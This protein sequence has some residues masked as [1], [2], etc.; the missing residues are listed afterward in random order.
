MK[1]LPVMLLGPLFLPFA[2][3]GLS[4]TSNGLSFEVATVKRTEPGPPPP[5][6]F[7]AAL[8]GLASMRGGPGASDPEWLS[9][10]SAKLGLILIRAYDLPSFQIVGPD[11]IDAD[12][13]DITAKVP[14]GTTKE[15]FRSML[16]NPLAERF[17]MKAHREMRTVPVYAL[18]VPKSGH[19]MQPSEGPG[20]PELKYINID[21]NHPPLPPY[22]TRIA[23]KNMTMADF[24]G[25]LGVSVAAGYID[26]KVVDDTR[27]TGAYNFDLKWYSP[28]V[29]ARGEGGV[30]FFE[31]LERQLGLKLE[32]R[33]A[34][35]EMLII[36][37]ISRIPAEN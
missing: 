16:Q 22:P 30:T 12:R 27:I 24:S 21:L 13:F 18:I 7:A 29:A 6:A 2:E 26:R 35:V 11:W 19:K 36:D 23:C 9:Y 15:Q 8:A 1:M 28:N 10:T 25:R 34:P 33:K 20:E 3:A 5:N 14:K 32:S 31:A 4:Q 37:S 17:Q